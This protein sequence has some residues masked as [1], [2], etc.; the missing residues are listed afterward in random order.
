MSTPFAIAN[1]PAGLKEPGF[2][3]SVRTDGDVGLASP[4]QR[5]LIFGYM[6]TGGTYAP[7]VPVRALSQAEVDAGARSYSMLAHAFAAAKAKIPVGAEI[8]LVPLIAPS[9]G[10]A[11]VLNVEIIGEPSAGVLSSGTAATAADTVTVRY[12]GR[13]V[14]VG[15]VKD[16]T[17]ATI[18]TDIKT[19]WDALD[20]PP[21]TCGRSGAA[22]TFTAQHKGAFDDGALEVTFT[23]NGASGV[24]AKLGTMTVSNAAGGDGTVVITMG[25]KTATVNVTS[26]DAATATGTGIVN[27]LLSD[28]YPIRA[29]QPASPTGTVTLLY[30]NNRPVR[31]LSISSTETGIST[32]AVADSVGTAGAG[33]PTLTAA[34]ANLSQIDDAWTAWALFFR[35]A[36]ELGSI[37]T[38][39]E[40]RA[41]PPLS[42][43]QVVVFGVTSSL[44]SVSNVNIPEATTPKLSATSRYTPIWAQ[45]APNAE[46][47][48]A[49]QLACAI[50][51]E[52]YVA[53]N[54]NG[55]EFDGSD[56]APIGLI[57]PQ[58]RPTIDERNTAIGLRHAPVTVNS[59]GKLAITWGGNCYKAKGFADQK[60]T[61]ISGQ[62]QIDYYVFSLSEYLRQ[63]FSGKKIKANGEPRTVNAVS[64]KSVQAAVVRWMK[65]LDDADLFDGW[66]TFRNAVLA[67]IVVSPTRIDI[68]VPFVPLADFDIGAVAASVQ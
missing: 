5:C 26:G 51:A 67:A 21:A 2:Y 17:Y 44:A 59:N 63:R 22:L 65:S 16:A 13:G 47:E 35:T 43:G 32:Q 6:S 45:S 24:A 41:V 18:A 68:N 50:G 42:L 9:G 19:A 54:W 3:V 30:C 10:T 40:A 46:F 28:T 29:A 60:L 34:L 31:P 23:S 4:T 1:L 38:H 33:N 15:I 49:A 55:F 27:K 64:L 8:W 66:E 12:R 57:H 39:V 53:R 25:A 56:S 61:K 52:T 20:N 58:D 11:Q 48:L 37:A 36:T 14:S 7:N 62:R